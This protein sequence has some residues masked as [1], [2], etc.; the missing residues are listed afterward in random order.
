MTISQ[1]IFEQLTDPFRIVLLAGLVYTMMRTRNQT[2]TIIPLFA[3]VVFVA[4]LI[5][6]TLGFTLS[7]SFTQL[8]GLGLITNT[9]LTAILFGGFSLYQRNKNK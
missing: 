4:A 8:F 3:G 9:I 6:S 2:G 1:V 5:P 7:E